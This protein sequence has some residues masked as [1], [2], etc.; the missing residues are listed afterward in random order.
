[1]ST[2]LPFL[3]YG[4]H[5]IDDDDIQAVVDALKSDYLTTGPRVAAFERALARMIDLIIYLFNR[6]S[7]SGICR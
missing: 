5:H 4:R 3:P 1:M 2:A 7:L 6:K